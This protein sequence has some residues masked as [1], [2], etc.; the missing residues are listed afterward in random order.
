[1]G[2]I[3]KDDLHLETEIIDQ[4]TGQPLPGFKFQ[5]MQKGKKKGKEMVVLPEEP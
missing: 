1:M 5:F 3:L 4:E 2:G